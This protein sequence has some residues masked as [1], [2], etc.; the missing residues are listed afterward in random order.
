MSS[1]TK[2]IRLAVFVLVAFYLG[3]C[4]PPP[5][6][7]VRVEVT[8]THTPG[9][10]PTPAPTWT[11]T[12]VPTATPIPPAHV[13]AIVPEGVSPLDP[14]VMGAAFVPP[15]GVAA[16]ANLSATV[17]DPAAEVYATF[18]LSEREGSRYLAAA[19]LQLPLAPLPGYWWLIVHAET[20]VPVKGHPARFFKI[21]PVVFRELTGT[22][23]S[24]VTMRVP[25]AFDEVLAQ[26]DQRAGGR[27]W[28]HREGEV[29]LWW[30]PGPTEDLLLSNALVALES[31]Y[32]ADARETAAPTPTE[33]S[34]TTWQDRRAFEFPETWSGDDGGPAVAWVIQGADEW[35]YILRV[36]ATG[37]DMIPVLH[38]EVAESFGFLNPDS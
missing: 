32:A 37:G 10:S 36:R 19:P 2:P 34:E 25:L 27:I 29:A 20:Q 12:P 28:R 5:V 23:P 3:A 11:P 38:Q 6:Q 22:L 15:D 4:A 9:P 1:K 18:E 33:V 30:T 35:L 26:G 31:T 7:V 8:A 14:V 13:E 16:E 17:M 24:G 21:E